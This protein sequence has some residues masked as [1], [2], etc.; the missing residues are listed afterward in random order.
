MVVFS[1]L[2]SFLSSTKSQEHPLLQ[3]AT[4]RLYDE[5]ELMFAENG[6]QTSLKVQEDGVRVSV[7]SSGWFARPGT[8]FSA[9]SEEIRFMKTL[10]VEL[11]PY[12][13]ILSAGISLTPGGRSSVFDLAYLSA[14]EKNK[15]ILRQ[16][17]GDVTEAHGAALLKWVENIQGRAYEGIQPGRRLLVFVNPHGGQGQAKALWQEK[18]E[19]ILAAAGCAV[20]VQYT[21]PI[22]SPTNAATVAH[23]LD[24]LQYDAL[25]PLSGDGIVSELLNGLATRPDARTALQIPIAPI[26]AGSGNALA[27]N[28]LGPENVV[29][30][31]LATLNAIKGVPM[32]LDICSVSQGATRRYSFLSQAFALMAQLDMGTEWIRWVGGI[33]FI[34]GYIWGALTRAQYQV[35][36]TMKVV[37][38]EKRT[39]VDA[40]NALQ[41]A[42]RIRARDPN[43][44]PPPTDSSMPPLLYGSTDAPL[45][46]GTIH[47]SI[48]AP[49]EPGWHTFRLPVQI[50][51]AGKLP[52][53]SRDSMILPLSGDDG[54]IDV[55]LV[56][57]RGIYASLTGMDGQEEGRFI[58]NS[59]VFYY[60]VEA[61]RCSPG[62]KSGYISIDGESIPY[63]PFQVENHPRLARIM[64]IDGL[65]KGLERVELPRI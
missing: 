14:K 41:Q 5:D 25:V 62:E 16:L 39:M 27:V 48:T 15:L 59:D 45:P 12:L 42:K 60:K 31:G 43:L 34:L 54:L 47:T 55:V 32:S 26:P 57:P 58:Q 28:L 17:S 19:P 46:L 20:D 40:Y 6:L 49:L 52:W 56:P 18:V 65:W 63:E 53:L 44:T 23:N 35:E 3:E 2:L 38:S 50:F 7:Y 4:S 8:L 1:A 22:N 33:R 10:D 21:G 24:V 37:E 11:V 13:N 36:I 29:D 51:C 61:Y 64:S 30:V 9:G